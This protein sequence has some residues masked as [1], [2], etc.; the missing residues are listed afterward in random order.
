MLNWYEALGD[1][2]TEH[3]LAEVAPELASHYGRTA[4][5]FVPMDKYS[6]MVMESG[7][8]QMISRAP[9]FGSRPRGPSDL[10]GA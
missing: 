10:S 4:M 6:D 8:L 7:T 3:E 2:L 1:E 5:S 9:E